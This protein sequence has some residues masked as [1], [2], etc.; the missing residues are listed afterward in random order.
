M[1]LCSER[2]L[3]PLPTG[4]RLAAGNLDNPEIGFAPT[5]GEGRGTVVSRDDVNLTIE[6]EGCGCGLR[7]QRMDGM[8]PLAEVGEELGD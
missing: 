5:T 1:P 2:T 7:L 8:P 4:F 6:S 3:P